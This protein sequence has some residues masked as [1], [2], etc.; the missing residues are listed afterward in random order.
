MTTDQISPPR[1]RILHAAQELLAE[2]GRDALSTRA[3]CARAGVQAQTIY[4]QFGD[5]QGLVDAATGDAW[6]RYMEAKL[7]EPA[8]DDPV[9]ELTAG[10]DNHVAFGLAN[11]AVYILTFGN[12][13]PEGPSATSGPSYDALAAV[14]SRIAAAGRLRLSVKAAAAAVHSAGIGVTLSLIA[15][16][17]AGR[18]E[19]HAALSAT[20]RDAVFRAVLTPSDDDVPPLPSARAVALKALLPSVADRFTPHEAALLGDWLDR[21]GEP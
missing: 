3:I 12:P 15:A 21:I 20:V 4:R 11:P 13:R 6:S 2:G 5:M 18:L 7:G 1:E 17:A 8:T 16:D 19:D 9:G 14:L 10:W